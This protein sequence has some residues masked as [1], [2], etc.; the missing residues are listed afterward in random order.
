MSEKNWAKIRMKKFVE[1]LNKMEIV[2]VTEAGDIV[3][4][5]NGL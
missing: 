5:I 2:S 3:G 4:K 1:F